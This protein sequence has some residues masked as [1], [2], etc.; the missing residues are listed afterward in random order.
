MLENELENQRM[1]KLQSLNG[2]KVMGLKIKLYKTKYE[3]KGK[4]Y[5]YYR[6][7]AQG[8]KDGSHCQINLGKSTSIEEIEEKI[9]SH[10][11]NKDKY[12]WVL[13]QKNS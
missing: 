5:E 12:S 8:K 4:Q 7:I 1:K 3:K 2:T 11:Q 13:E 9:I 6:L 10:V